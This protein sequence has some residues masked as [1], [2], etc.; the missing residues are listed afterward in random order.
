MKAIIDTL[1]NGWVNPMS[2]NESD[3]IF[4]STG[5]LAPQE[6]IQDLLNAHTIGDTAYQKFKKECLESP[7][8]TTKFYERMSKLKMQTFSD[9]KNRMSAKASGKQVI[10]HADRNMFGRMIWQHKVGLWM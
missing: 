1:E 7:Q 8:T 4:H 6:I 10:L 3:I 5:R 9:M 2:T